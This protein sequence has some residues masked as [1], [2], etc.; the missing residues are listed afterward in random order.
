VSW[1]RR[2]LLSGLGVG[3]A[4]TLIAALGC[5]GGTRRVNAVAARRVDGAEVRSWLRRAVEALGAEHPVVAAHAVIANRV[6]AALDLRGSGVVHGQRAAVVIRVDDGKGRVSERATGE[7]SADAVDSLVESLRRT[8][9]PAR[10]VDFGEPDRYGPV[11]GDLD[12]DSDDVWLDRVSALSRRAD[13]VATSRVVYRGAWIDADAVT[14][15][16]VASSPRGGRDR[17]QRLV[18]SRAGL[19]L[20]SWSGSAPMVGQVERGAVGGPDRAVLKDADLERAA[21][22]ALEL[23][24][25][26]TISA[27]LAT[28]VLMPSVVARLA[29]VAIAPVLAAAARR[30]PDLAARRLVDTSIGA[31]SITI[32]TNPDPTRYG[33]YHFDDEG[34]D[35]AAAP[36][37]ESGLLRG[38]VGDA[39]GATAVKRSVGGAGL[40]A[41]HTG[42]VRSMIGHLAWAPGPAAGDR[43][44]DPEALVTELDDAWIVDDAGI[45]HVDPVSWSATLEV[46]R[47]RRVKSGAET[48]HVHAGIELAA[49]IPDL[50]AATT[51]VSSTVEPFVVRDGDGADAR[52][53]SLEVPAIVTRVRLAPRRPA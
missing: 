33:G 30:R 12:D 47:A 2:E 24:T 48:G 34:L 21:K 36:L 13:R 35:G 46:G 20:M 19:V 18:R 42:A 29:D 25:P 26:G 50:L 28:V 38:P 11:G 15:W 40:R 31:P 5:G 43:P 37:I 32:A 41:G 16:H 49:S 7:L 52:W 53:R 23:T 3:A 27:Q 10:S 4:S 1:S 6:T 9:A 39:H 22:G 44:V 51:R 14:I 45:G 8:T 17:T